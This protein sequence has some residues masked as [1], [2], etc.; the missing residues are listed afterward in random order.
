M[1]GTTHT[2]T[3]TVQGDSWYINKQPFTLRVKYVLLFWS[4]GREEGTVCLFL[5]PDVPLFSSPWCPK[6]ESIRLQLELSQELKKCQDPLCSRKLRQLLVW[7][8]QN[9]NKCYRKAKVHRKGSTGTQML[10]KIEGS[11][12][13]ERREE[14]AHCQPLPLSDVLC[15]SMLHYF[16]L[17]S[18]LLPL[19]AFSLLRISTHVLY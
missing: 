7:N 17:I 19:P 5:S 4:M 1:D 12:K 13:S 16:F 10:R 6:K 11:W 14:L 18:L 15:P 9:K 3:H 8:K 2:H